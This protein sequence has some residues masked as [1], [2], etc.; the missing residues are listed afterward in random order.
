MRCLLF[1]TGPFAVPA[2]EN[3]IQSRHRVIGLVTRPV[4]D[5][6]KRRKTAENPTRDLALQKQLQIFSPDNVNDAEAIRWLQEQQV[7]LHVVC[8]YGQILSN[9][10]LATAR[11]GGINLHGSLLPKYRGAAP[12]QWAIYQGE[13]ETGVTV[14][15]MTP[16]L[17][18]G[19]I[20]T[21]ASLPILVEDTSE[22]LEPRL[23]RLGIEPVM[24]AIELLEKWDGKAQVGKSQDPKLASLAPRLR[25]DDG[26]IDWRR[27][28]DQ[29][30]NQIR[31]F[32]PWPGSF[33]TLADPTLKQPLRLIFSKAKT[34]SSAE[35]GIPEDLSPEI[36]RMLP[37]SII[38]CDQNQL[39]CQTGGGYL[40]ILEIQPAG[41][42]PMAV[43]EFLRGQRLSAGMRMGTGHNG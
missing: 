23:A 11:L 16:K 19:P 31:A 26:Q 33:T 4:E 24:E 34:V 29:I 36:N 43:A 15:H 5:S 17:D 1:G 41:K 38:L 42:K 13:T 28:A 12:I 27:T 10:C 14:I 21:S 30:V 2:F 8:D 3:L 22:T 25:K 7:D 39:V 32:Q 40:S 20:L 18:G 6:G 35:I 9:Q 37:G